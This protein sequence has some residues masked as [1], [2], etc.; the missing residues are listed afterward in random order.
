MPTSYAWV[1]CIAFLKKTTP[2]ESS[3]VPNL[4][5]NTQKQKVVESIFVSLG[6]NDRSAIMK[7]CGKLKKTGFSVSTDLPAELGKRRKE[8][9]AIGYKL[10]TSK[11]AAE[12]VAETRVVQGG[13][14][15]WLDVKKKVAKI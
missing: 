10:K 5:R 8:L 13:I 14:R 7:E 9:L 4:R 3:A 15:L 1:P 2:S 11:S 12:K 6:D